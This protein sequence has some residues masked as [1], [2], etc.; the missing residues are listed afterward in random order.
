MNCSSSCFKWAFFTV[1]WLQ[2]Q[3]GPGQYEPG[4]LSKPESKKPPG[5]LSTAQRNDKV[6]QRFFTRNFVSRI[7]SNS[8]WYCSI[9][10]L[11]FHFMYVKF[12]VIGI[13]TNRTLLSNFISCHY[14]TVTL[15]ILVILLFRKLLLFDLFTRNLKPTCVQSEETVIVTIQKL[16]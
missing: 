11:V 1:F 5:F 2:T 8:K 4:E 12:V 9:E 15:M 7:L 16:D 13:S 6:S 3:P 10:F 14:N